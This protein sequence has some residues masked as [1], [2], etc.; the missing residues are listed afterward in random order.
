M[1]S[2]ILVLMKRYLIPLLFFSCLVQAA[3]D[4]HALSV[5]SW[6]VPKDGEALRNM[7]VLRT[8][9]AKLQQNLDSRLL[10]HYPGGDEGTLWAYELRAWLVSL[11]L[12]ST[13]I[14]L[15]PGGGYGQALRLTVVHQEPVSESQIQRQGQQTMRR[16][17][18]NH[19]TASTAPEPTP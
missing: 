5:E 2:D 9:M 19:N 7:P 4:T 16:T 11:G 13:R 3:D 8:V 10:I 1:N 6:A 15:Q 17:G 14:E 18:E 12:A